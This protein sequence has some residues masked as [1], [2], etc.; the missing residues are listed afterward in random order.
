MHAQA[1][2]LTGHTTESQAYTAHDLTAQL[3]PSPPVLGR[4]AEQLFT[5]GLP[6]E[7]RQYEGTCTE[8][9]YTDPRT[10]QYGPASLDR[11][12]RVLWAGSKHV[13]KTVPHGPREPRTALLEA[14]RAQWALNETVGPVTVGMGGTTA[15]DLGA[16]L[17][18]NGRL[19]TTQQMPSAGSKTYGTP[20]VMP[21][22]GFGRRSIFD[23]S[24]NAGAFL[25][26][27]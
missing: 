18:Q 27:A 11:M 5:H 8:L 10:R 26:R 1:G 23:K 4:T 2:H 20:P 3:P 21:A 25:S 12:P 15:R 16:E 22:N 9:A 13:D 17:Q 7:P 19:L 14:K 24:K 6:H